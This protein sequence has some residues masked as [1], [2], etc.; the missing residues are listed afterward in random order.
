MTINKMDID[1]LIPLFI[2]VIAIMIEFYCLYTRLFQIRIVVFYK[3]KT[4]KN[5]EVLLSLLTSCLPPNRIIKISFL[6]MLTRSYYFSLYK[7]RQIFEVWCPQF[8]S[9]LWKCCFYP[10]PSLKEKRPKKGS[11]FDHTKKMCSQKITFDLQT[12]ITIIQDKEMQTS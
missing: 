6:K 10:P 4:N 9:H 1:L 5:K 7:N 3:T 12:L 8:R 2:V 11:L